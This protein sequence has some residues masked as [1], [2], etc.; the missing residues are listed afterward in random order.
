MKT[1]SRTEYLDLERDRAQRISNNLNDEI[2]RRKL[3]DYIAELKD[4]RLKVS[5]SSL[6][7]ID[8]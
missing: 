7:D 2:S 3:I 1:V 6:D 8:I 4:E 5:R